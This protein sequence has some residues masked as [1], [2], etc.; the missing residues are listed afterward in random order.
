[1]RNPK[2]LVWAGLKRVNAH[3]GSIGAS[4]GDGVNTCVPVAEMQIAEMLSW[5]QFAVLRREG[6]ARRFRFEAAA[7]RSFRAQ[8]TATA[9]RPPPEGHT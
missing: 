1:M 5:R 8:A 7:S 6:R 3:D 9:W 4:G 2:D